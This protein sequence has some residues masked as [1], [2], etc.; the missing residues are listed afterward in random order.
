M[1]NSPI[2]KAVLYRMV[3]EQHVCPYGLKAK[4]LL[5]RQ[6]YEVEDNYLTTREQVDAFKLKHNVSTTPQ[7]FI[8]GKRI[9]GYDDL[10]VYFGKKIRDPKE[11][12]YRPVIALFAVTALMAMAMSYASF[13]NPFTP[14]ALG[15]FIAF[16]MS[17][18][19]LLKLQNIESFSTMFLNYDLLAKRWVPY[20]YIY[21]FAEGLAGILMI[22]GALNWLSVPIALFIGTVGAVSVFKAVYIDKR[23]LK[24]ACVGGDSKV[25]LGFISLTENLMM[26]G[27]ALFMLIM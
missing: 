19:A 3:M 15:W 8:N 14:H 13:T 16:S 23:E 5:K 18:L 4:D 24:C 10:R 20:S 9:G 17:V 7:T 1:N 26:I 21:P 6:G 27:M 11:K 22:A 2:K 12:S 25:P